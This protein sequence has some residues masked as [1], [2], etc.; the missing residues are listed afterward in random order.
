M[1]LIIPE[2]QTP[3]DPVKQPRVS[4]DQPNIGD[5]ARQIGKIGV[6]IEVR[7]REQERAT[8][9]REARVTAVERLG[10][11][12]TQYEQD[13]NV[14]G[15]SERFNADVEALKTELASSLPEGRMR[16]DFELDFR[17]VVAPQV[18]AVSKREFALRRDAGRADL[19]AALRSYAQQAGSAPDDES[20]DATLK[21]AASDVGAAVAAGWIS[22]QEAEQLLSGVM[23]E[24]V[25]A[26]A[27]RALQDDPAGFL[28]DVKAGKYTLPPEQLARLEG[29]A[30]SAVTREEARV[31][32]ALKADEAAVAKQRQLDVDDAIKILESGGTYDGLPELFDR[33]AGTEDEK[34]L[35]ATLAAVGTEQNFTILSP[36]QQASALASIDATP[37]SDPDDIA[38]R[39]RLHKIAAETKKSIQTDILT[40]VDQRGILSVDPINLSDP[41]SIKR[42]I[43][44]ADA[45]F[46]DFG[47]SAQDYRLFTNGERDTLQASIEN[48]DPDAQLSVAVSIIEGFGDYAPRALSE[49]GA[50][51]PVFGFAA[52][53]LEQT[54]NLASARMMLVGRKMLADKSGARP[55]KSVRS[56]VRAKFADIYPAG[57]RQ[58]LET[59]M[60]GA[61]AYY[62]ASAIDIDPDASDADKRAAYED[63]LQAVLGRTM[64]GNTQMGG[65]Q[66]VNGKPTLLPPNL[67]AEFV[68]DALLNAGAEELRAA[69]ITGGDA[70]WGGDAISN[71]AHTTGEELVAVP[72][73]VRRQASPLANATLL[74]I[75]GG[76]YLIGIERANG[77]IRYLQDEKSADGFFRLNLEALVGTGPRKRA[78]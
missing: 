42:R 69:S 45:A 66:T 72:D 24:S 30:K 12:R 48:G 35:A 38:R 47:T 21:V 56:A 5:A 33:I 61:D 32:R 55:G 1:P 65:I 43:A 71:P 25:S 44:V 9:M 57:M 34:R 58:R 77:E 62:A 51:D 75:G 74:S 29:Q 13:P 6:A 2:A 11:L 10:A 17:Q 22:E 7:R 46:V 14:T 41:S 18:Q 70:L 78:P 8:M 50:S 54:G 60:K 31:Q 16:K 63:A 4:Y 3:F 28:E 15:L 40:H 76:Q 19:S 53:L 52:H 39:K 20:R 27:I 36:A 23:Q 59:L 67:T 64:R 68:E 26:A 73:T 37:T 49:I